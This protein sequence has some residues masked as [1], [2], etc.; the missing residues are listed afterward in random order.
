VSPNCVANSIQVFG[1]NYLK[2]WLPITNFKIGWEAND[3]VSFRSLTFS[4]YFRQRIWS[5]PFFISVAEKCFPLFISECNLW[6]CSDVIAYTMWIFSPAIY[7]IPC[8]HLQWIGF[9]ILFSN[10][11]NSI[12]S[13]P[14]NSIPYRPSSMDWIPYFHLQ[15]IG[16]RIFTG[17]HILFSN[18]LSSV[19]S[20][21]MDWI[22]YFHLKWIGFRIFIYNG[23]D[24][25]FSSP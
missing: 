18:G 15:W 12:F 13:P 6:P 10:E 3:V 21:P 19:F 7:W 20:P 23:L 9:H 8:F 1:Q 2:I 14:M 16:F 24:S 25:V 5:S 22:T 17:F 11:L 4:A